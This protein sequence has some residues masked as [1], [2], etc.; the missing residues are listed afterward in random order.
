MEISIC[1]TFYSGKG[2]LNIIIL[3]SDYKPQRYESS[4]CYIF[5]LEPGEWEASLQ[6]VAPQ[7]GVLV[8]V[9]DAREHLIGSKKISK[10][11]TFNR[12]LKFKVPVSEI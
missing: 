5:S 2:H 9:F 12:F 11:G 10:E 4:G 6:G 3:H 7:G 8:E 1:A